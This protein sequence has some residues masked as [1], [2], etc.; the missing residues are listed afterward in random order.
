MRG[1]FHHSG[2][3]RDPRRGTAIVPRP[4][5]AALKLDSA[6]TA[7]I[8]R[9]HERCLALGLSRIE[10]PDHARVPANELLLRRERNLRLHLHA[11]PVMELLHEQI[12]NTH[13]M[14]ALTDASGTILL[15]IGD[16]D[17]LSRAARVALAPGADWSEAGKGT[18]AVGTALVSEQPTLVHA[19]EHFLHANHFLT[20]SAAPILDPRG[21]VLGVLDVSGDHRSYHQHTMALVKMSA[22][23]IENHWLSDDWR[24]G[25]RLHFHR[26]VEC[27]GTL[28]EGILAVE[29]D[30][31][32]SGANR[33]A[34]EQLGLAGAALRQQT[35]QSLFDLRVDALVDRFRSPLALPLAVHTADG[36]V[37]HLH[38]RF[39][40]PM[41]APLVEAVVP[42]AAAPVAA[43]PAA[44]VPSPAPA[45]PAR[46][47][48]ALAALC[49]GD[50]A[51]ERLV[52]QLRRVRDAGVPVQL[53]GE[54]GT[55][56]ARLAQALHQDSA[57]A[58]HRFVAF[59][60][61]TTAAETA[62]AQLAEALQRAAGGTL[63]LN[64]PQALP[65]TLQARLLQHL[66][67]H[68]LTVVCA[69]RV[70]LA[71]ALQQQTLREDL[72]YQL[73]GLSLQ[74]PPLR[75]RSDLPAL[76]L[77]LLNELPLAAR[78]WQIAPE[79]MALLQRHPW[80]GNVRELKN[81]LRTAA[82]LAGEASLLGC[83]HL[84]D[85]LVQA[86]AGAG[87]PPP[88]APDAP[89]DAQ[90]LAAM[91]RALAAAGGNISA[92]A[93]ALG[94]SRNTLYRKLRWRN[95]A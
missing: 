10:S 18:N 46:R 54:H 7:E 42:A 88:A 29:A 91:Q 36:Q 24:H 73:Q 57:R 89:L 60:G 66:R 49:C 28:Q 75:E 51:F 64:Q 1:P 8:D 41:W 25:L 63:L 2:H 87:A 34:L 13:S 79:A 59:D 84:P 71:R 81:V 17:F 77:A 70:P 14:V 5:A 31:R 94:I 67:S 11:A 50:A 12:V 83:E 47:R 82:A 55:G 61:S 52:D 4:I 68:P 72:Y 90:Q 76:A 92:A 53:V 93:K 62:E 65:L 69:S 3:S 19:D 74:L 38:A 56:Q 6:H 16:D 23:M 86:A 15:S 37:F 58:A 32:I 44:V 40:G 80:P 26:R 9:S 39:N 21:N 30:G 33:G 35:L 22:R 48:S 45:P 43:A 78:G 85:A 20:C 95:K 27:I